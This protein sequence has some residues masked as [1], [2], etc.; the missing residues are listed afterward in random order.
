MLEAGVM[1]EITGLILAEHESFRRS[2]L[3]L[4]DLRPLG[5]SPALVAAWRDLADRLEVRAAAEE[6]IFYP[7]LLKRGS[8]EAPE[9]TLDAI[10]DHN[11]IRDAIR[12]GAATEVASLEWR[13]AVLECRK[14]NDEHLAE[15]ERDVIPNFRER[16]DDELRSVLGRE[17]LQFRAR[18]SGARGVSGDDLDS[19]AYVEENL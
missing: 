15:G 5:A 14:A 4:R 18:H 17:W 11:Q 10:G 8:D 6:D 12:E 1:T 9:E 3:D 2:F 7:V 19:G 13:D 16:S